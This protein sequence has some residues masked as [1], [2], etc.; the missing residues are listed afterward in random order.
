MPL[1]GVNNHIQY[2]I[3]LFSLVFCVC[4]VFL[5][6]QGGK[7][8]KSA[9]YAGA[10]YFTSRFGLAWVSSEITTKKARNC[11]NCLPLNHIHVIK[12]DV[13]EIRNAESASPQDCSKNTRTPF[14]LR[15]KVWG[16]VWAEITFYMVRDGKIQ[17]IRRHLH[18]STTGTTVPFTAI[19]QW[20]APVNQCSLAGS[21]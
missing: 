12:S 14:L 20:R 9:H 15:G 5:E 7:F 2:Y 6:L 13:P 3:Q 11:R 17:E 18:W 16:E 4:F 21:W 8:R 1:Q 19:G 10:S